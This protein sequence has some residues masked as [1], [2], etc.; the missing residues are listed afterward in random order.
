MISEIYDVIVVGAGH[1]GCEAAAAAANLGSKTLLV[2]MNMQ[3]IGQMSCNP[4]MGGIAKGQIVREI[5][6]MG[7]YSGIVADKSAIQF[8]MLN[9]SKGPA[10]WS[11]R[12]QNDRMLF[13]EE[14][15][16]AL[17]NTPNLDFF[18]DMVK[19][20]IVENNKVTGVVTSLGIEIKAKSVVLTNGTFLNG[21]IHVGDKQLGGGRMGEPRAFGITEQLVTLGF[22]A[23]RMK[24]G[25]PP[26]VDGRSLDYSKMEEQKGDENPQK[27]SY[28]DTPKLTKQLSCHI[29]YT[30]E[31]VHDILREGFDRSPMFNGTIQSLGPRYCPSIEDKINR[32]AERNR[33]QL[34]VE[35]EGWKTVEIYVNGF[36]SS[37]PEDVQIKAMK[38]I[39]GFENVKVFRPGYAIEYDYF[40]PTQLKHTLE[41]K[42]IDNLY[43]A[44]QI[45]GTTGY[46]EAAGQGLIAGINAHNKVHE[47]GDF[48]LNRDE[49]YIGVL[50]DDLITKGTEEPYRMFTSRAEYRLLLR[51]DNADIRLT[52]KAYQLGLAKEDRLRKMET[53]VSESQALEEFLRETSL[54]PGIINPVLESIESNPVDQ[55]YR[56]AQILTRPHMTLGKLD[57]IDFIKEVSGQ[58]NDE[59][60][61]QAEINIKYK[62]YIEKEKENV[63]KLN[64]LENIKIPED[65]DYTKLSSLSAE[66]KQKMSNVRPKTIAQAGRISGVSP[67]DINVLLVYLGR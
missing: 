35:P 15:R 12:T 49:A 56:A 25:T 24:T 38:Q 52:E 29:V 58:Y 40:P 31:T 14:W 66:A 61:E 41:T 32:F 33:H 9:L 63:A 11:P 50:I 28:L 17:E 22:E 62:G 18:Q 47:K 36:S 34:F 57:E 3:T 37:L 21:L 43:F 51:Q 27:F 64:R 46:E 16:L 55:A 53:K 39:P 4:A 44:G 6:A 59:V 54:K 42:L 19:Q 8:K 5:D 48:I 45:N 10:M 30:N 7:G 65:F 23:G 67:A 1:A 26:R 60:R 20:L 2:T 13:A